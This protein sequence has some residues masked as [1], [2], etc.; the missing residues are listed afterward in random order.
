MAVVD[1]QE[2]ADP[3]RRVDLRKECRLR[4]RPRTAQPIV[5]QGRPIADSDVVRAQCHDAGSA[6]SDH[7]QPDI[8][9][10]DGALSPRKT[11]TFRRANSVQ[12]R[13]G[14]RDVLDFD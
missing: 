6:A 3:V 10:W 9:K 8:Q 2:L 12:Q 5:P 7:Y 11:A 1:E 4:P 14:C 13:E